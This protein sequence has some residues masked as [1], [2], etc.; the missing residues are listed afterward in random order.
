MFAALTRL[1]FESLLSRI[2]H[3][4]GCPQDRLPAIGLNMSCRI[5]FINGLALTRVAPALRIA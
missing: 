4:Q 5:V 1:F 3:R 2:R